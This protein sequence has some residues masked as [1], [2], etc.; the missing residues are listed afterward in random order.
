M[1]CCER[2]RRGN[3]MLAREFT[4]WASTRGVPDR[5]TEELLRYAA[6]PE[7]MQEACD[8]MEPAPP[9][10]PLGDIVEMTDKDP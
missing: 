3:A 2:F 1:V 6:S 10:Y 4:I 7:E 9:V 8:V 5:T